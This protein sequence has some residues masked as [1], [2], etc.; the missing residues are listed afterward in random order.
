MFLYKDLITIKKCN[1]YN[2]VYISIYIRDLIRRSKYMKNI[3]I[4]VDPLKS[5]FLPFLPFSY[6]QVTFSHLSGIQL[7]I[8][9]QKNFEYFSIFFPI[10]YL[11]TYIS[12]YTYYTPTTTIQY[13]GVG[14][15]R[16][17]QP[18]LRRKISKISFFFNFFDH[19]SNRHPLHISV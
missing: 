7:K 17:I 6:L 2:S 15:P 14:G 10:Q 1:L 9:A 11:Y 12:M 19:F 3:D 13:S 16:L 8:R 5:G 4:L 18:E